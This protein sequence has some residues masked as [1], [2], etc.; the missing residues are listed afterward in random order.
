MY[1]KDAYKRIVEKPHMI[2]G[3]IWGVGECKFA[4]E[5]KKTIIFDSMI[6]SAY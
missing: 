2:L 1:G 3:C 4:G 6:E 5:S